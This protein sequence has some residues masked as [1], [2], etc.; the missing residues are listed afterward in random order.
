MTK[1]DFE[2][3]GKIIASLDVNP[4]DKIMIATIFADDLEPTNKRF[5]RLR[6]INLCMKR[7][8]K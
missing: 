7:V 2:L 6:F 1:K 4:S 5:N 8:D 3:I